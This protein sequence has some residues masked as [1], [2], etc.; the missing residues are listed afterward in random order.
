MADDR[1]PLCLRE[2]VRLSGATQ[3]RLSVAYWSA[4]NLWGVTVLDAGTQVANGEG[5]TIE[6]AYEACRASIAPATDL[7]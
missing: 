6:A 4:A 1:Q 3:P 7:F 2:L 5:P